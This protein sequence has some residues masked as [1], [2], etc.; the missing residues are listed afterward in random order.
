MA[1]SS[2]CEHCAPYE[3]RHFENWL[4]DVLALLIHPFFGRITPAPVAAR[5]TDTAITN[6]LVFFGIVRPE[7]D[8][9]LGKI[10][11]IAAIFIKRGRARGLA[12]EALRGPSG[13]LTFFRMGAGGRMRVIDRLPGAGA[14]T[15][16]ADDKWRVKRELLKSGYP[17]APGR[18]FWWF[19]RRRA[20]RYAASLGFPVVVK[21]R[22]GSLS[23][24]MFVV[25]DGARLPGAVRSVSSYAP[26]FLIEKFVP[27]AT[28][29]RA[30]VVDPPATATKENGGGRGG[31]K[32]VFV[33][34]RL[35]Q[36]VTGDG[37]NT[38]LALARNAGFDLRRLDREF[39]KE[40]G[41]AADGIIPRGKRVSLHRKAVMALHSE[42][43]PV[44][45]GEVHPSILAMCR[46][47]A[48]RFAL[49]LVGIDILMRDH[50]IPLGAQDAAVL[51]LNT[52]PNIVMHTF[53]KEGREENEVA[54]ALVDLAAGAPAGPATSSISP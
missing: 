19:E 35:P 3:P 53:V 8:F 33:V 1:S 4:D 31:G 46:S 24:H 17:V 54:D 18:A 40:Q 37:E 45:P 23:Q 22:R 28:L 42:I 11:P 43:V 7:R 30:T 32:R 21:P 13:Y 25:K 39:L 51:E 41:A 16:L 6:A 12:F 47:I 15:F 14:N 50:R 27:G 9:P 38:L 36:A 10:N 29:Y 5:F 52:L 44:P 48:E 49:P 26:A 20:A 2:A 34:K